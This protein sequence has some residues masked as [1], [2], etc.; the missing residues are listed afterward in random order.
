MRENKMSKKTKSVRNVDSAPRT[1]HDSKAIKAEQDRSLT[2][3]LEDTFPASDP[4]S[5]L[6]FTQSLKRL[7]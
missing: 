1:E 5:S 3:A 2:S 6:R 7:A 4:V